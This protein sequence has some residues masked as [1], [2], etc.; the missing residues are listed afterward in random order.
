M[1]TMRIINCSVGVSV[2]EKRGKPKHGVF[3][4]VEATL[5]A[6]WLKL[7][8]NRAKLNREIVEIV[9]KFA[10]KITI[11]IKWCSVKLIL[12]VCRGEKHKPERL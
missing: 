7:K 6:R 3:L 10:L 5:R 8:L 12:V 4:V 1:F 2:C 11:V 9:G